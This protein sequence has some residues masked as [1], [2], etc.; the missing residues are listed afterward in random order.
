[1]TLVTVG[2]P[3][4]DPATV[5]FQIFEPVLVVIALFAV[6]FLLNGLILAP[7][8]DRLHPEPVYKSSTRMPRAAGAAIA[9]VSILGLIITVGTV[10]TMVDDADICYSA[11]GGGEGCA[12]FTR[13]VLP[14]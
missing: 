10:K 12:V 5:D 7:L 14:E 13:D 3:V 11:A 8:T 4:F 2:Q 9:L 6:L 1:M